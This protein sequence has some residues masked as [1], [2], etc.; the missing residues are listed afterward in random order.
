MGIYGEQV[1]P[2]LMNRVMA[3]GAIQRIRARVCSALAGD[4]VE[5]GFGTGHNLPYLP[6]AVAS[7]RAVE[8]SALAIRL[9]ADRIAGSPAPVLLAG[10]DG[11]AMPLEDASADA[12]L[13]TWSL[14]SIPDAVAAVREA[15][16]VLRPGGTFHFVEHG[17][18]PD[19]G[20]RR[21]QHRLDGLQQRVACGCHL[22]RDIPAIVEA[23]GMLIERLDRYYLERAPRP[24]SAMSEGVAV[25]LTAAPTRPQHE[26][27]LSLPRP[28]AATAIAAPASTT[29]A[30]ED[31][32]SGVEVDVAMKSIT[33]PAQLQSV[34]QGRH[35]V[36]DALQAWGLQEVQDTAAL[37]SSEL[38]TNAVI[39]A[40]T[41]LSMS[42]RM[43]DELV[44][45]VH[46]GG[47]ATV[48]PPVARVGLES[49]MLVPD[50]DAENG[51]GL[52]LVAA[53]SRAW[54]IRRNTA[55]KTVWFSLAL[56]AV[57]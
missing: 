34:P 20:V 37:L 14:C 21:W 11:Q 29:V 8:P 19:V 46:D 12:V 49:L 40:H 32:V 1:F 33:L 56:P 44:V 28:A 22:T 13:C 23:G 10:L 17:A 9:A 57:R 43:D 42:I 7:V 52:L 55:G 54:G 36:C 50:L 5:I 3:D 27:D 16:R 4:V 6:L 35:F 53:L 31:L 26:A 30:R 48:L 51:R 2:R 45:E 47:T 38:L 39:H 24:F 41:E 18:A 15:G 25:V